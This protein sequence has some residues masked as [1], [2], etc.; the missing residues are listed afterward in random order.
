MQQRILGF[1][2]QWHIDSLLESSHKLDAAPPT[3]LHNV[4]HK[5]EQV[6][7]LLIAGCSAKHLVPALGDCLRAREVEETVL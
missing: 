4:V 2:R 5:I 6:E 1:E 7:L 3:V